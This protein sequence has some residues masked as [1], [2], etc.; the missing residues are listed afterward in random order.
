[1]YSK[2]FKVTEAHLKLLKNA[3]ISWQNCEFGAPEI[4][5]K[6]PYGNSDVVGDILEI[7]GIPNDEDN[8]ALTD[9]AIKLHKDTE[10]VLQICL[11]TQ[12]FK[13]GNYIK[14]DIPNRWQEV[15]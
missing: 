1:M 9:F 10:T 12:Q 3:Y 8:E 11:D 4:N 6:R 7:I 15:K 14:K 5:P 13:V 2:T